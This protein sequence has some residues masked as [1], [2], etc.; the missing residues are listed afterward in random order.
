MDKLKQNKRVI[1]F[2]VV[3]IAAIII[4]SSTPGSN[5]AQAPEGSLTAQAGSALNPAFNQLKNLQKFTQLNGYSLSKTSTMT[6]YNYFLQVLDSQKN[7]VLSAK[8]DAQNYTS[9]NAKVLVFPIEGAGFN[10]SIAGL[11]DG[12]YTVRLYTG[13]SNLGKFNERK[14]EIKN[15]S[16]STLQAPSD[17][18][19]SLVADVQDSPKS[20]ITA[21]ASDLLGTFT[22]WIENVRALFTPAARKGGNNLDNKKSI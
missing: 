16:N 12:A 8:L 17:L 9:D 21:F 1:T 7:I 14:I 18:S 3:A 2:T 11:T 22:N 20:K 13:L 4:F 6:Y 15:E 19:V 5:I 10:F